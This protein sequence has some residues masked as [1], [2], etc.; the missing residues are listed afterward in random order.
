M[1]SKAFLIHEGLGEI[2]KFNKIDKDQVFD[3]V[4]GTLE[5]PFPI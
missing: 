4:S 1:D 2:F 3:S 5:E